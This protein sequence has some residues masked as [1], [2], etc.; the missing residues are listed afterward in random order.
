MGCTDCQCGNS[1]DESK[2]KDD[3]SCAIAPLGL[4]IDLEEG[5][6]PCGKEISECCHKDE[7]L[8]KMEKESEN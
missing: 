6:C 1:G 2:M 7:I 5:V 8:E 4:E 3:G